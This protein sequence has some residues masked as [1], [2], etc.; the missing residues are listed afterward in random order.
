MKFTVELNDKM[1]DEEI[2]NTVE[3]Y[4]MMFKEKPE[5]VNNMNRIKINESDLID[6]YKE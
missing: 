3:L 1:S 4:K 2:L 6:N 5:T